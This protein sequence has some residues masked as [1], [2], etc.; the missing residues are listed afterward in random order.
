MTNDSDADGDELTVSLDADALE[1]DLAL[2]ADGSFTY[3]PNQNYTGPDS[4]T[5]RVIDGEFYNPPTDGPLHIERGTDFTYLRSR[6]KTDTGS[7]TDSLAVAWS[8]RF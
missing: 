2:N 7:D 1:G 3:Q 4:F 6:T 5:Y 8:R